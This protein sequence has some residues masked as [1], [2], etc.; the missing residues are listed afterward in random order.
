MKLRE[1]EKALVVTTEELRQVLQDLLKETKTLTL[2]PDKSLGDLI[3]EMKQ[4]TD[5]LRHAEAQA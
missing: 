5:E 2:D 4:A 1:H 3:N